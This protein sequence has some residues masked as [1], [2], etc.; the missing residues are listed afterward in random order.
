MKKW[1]L[2]IALFFVT[3]ASFGCATY[4]HT[5]RPYEPIEKISNIHIYYDDRDE[6]GQ[7]LDESATPIKILEEEL[8]AEMITDLESFVFEDVVPLFMPSD[9]NLYIYMDLS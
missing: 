8:Y 6:R 4:K 7:D 3:I 2:A 5:F 1:F 9:P